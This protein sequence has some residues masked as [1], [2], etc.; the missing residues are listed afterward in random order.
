MM[1]TDALAP[2][3]LPARIGP[4]K[5]NNTFLDKTKLKKKKKKRNTRIIKK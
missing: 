5:S 1:T 4:M 3:E 2:V